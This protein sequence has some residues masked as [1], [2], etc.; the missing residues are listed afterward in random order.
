MEL[1]VK[2]TRDSDGTYHAACGALPGCSSRGRTPREA[3][4]RYEGAARIYIASLTN[5]VPRHVPLA[6]INS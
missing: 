1:A 3:V 5:F 6:V 4:E 2:T